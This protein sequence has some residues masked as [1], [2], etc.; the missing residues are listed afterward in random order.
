MRIGHDITPDPP[1]FSEKWINETIKHFHKIGLPKKGMQIMYNIV[2]PGNPSNVS[3]I[4]VQMA[5]DYI[6]QMNMS[7]DSNRAILTTHSRALFSEFPHDTL[8]FDEDPLNSLLDIKEFR[9]SDVCSIKA[10]GNVD[11]L[12]DVIDYLY[13]AIPDEFE[14]TPNFDINRDK[15]IDVVSRD[16]DTTGNK[17]NVIEFFS[18][19]FFVRNKYNSNLFYYINKKEL[20]TNKKI[21]ILSATIPSEMYRN[22]YGD[23][24]KIYDITDVEQEG[25]VIQHTSRSCSRNGLGKYGTMISKKV[26]DKPVI[27]FKSFGHEFNNPVQDMYFGNCSGYDSLKGRNIA[28]VG[29]PHHNTVEYFLTAKVM[30]ID[31]DEADKEMAFQKIEH[32][33]FRFKFNC[34]LHEGLR[35]IQLSLIESDLIQAVGRA[36]TL[37]TEATVDLYSNF[38]LRISDEFNY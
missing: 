21:I 3:G 10:I 19:S 35:N 2:S 32:N 27:T 5:K 26:G 25:T 1:V 24:V 33:G 38:P 31:F 20:P 34:F 36:R 7:F 28:V 23:R 11:G 18:S 37:R 12:D 13:G 9:L 14:P 17:S 30:G 29:T 16:K 15:L 8:I 6:D 22:L 4:D